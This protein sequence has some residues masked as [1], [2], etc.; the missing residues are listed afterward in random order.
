MLASWIIK[1]LLIVSFMVFGY[2]ITYILLVKK[3]NKNKNHNNNLIDQKLKETR[4]I[5]R[6]GVI[7]MNCFIFYS[8]LN[9]FFYDY[10]IR[11]L[12]RIPLFEFNYVA[13]IVGFLLVIIGNIILGF[14]Y[15]K[16]G[17]YW[18][19]PTDRISKKKVII[20]TGIYRYIRHPIYL[21][22]IIFTLGFEL[23]LLDLFS[24][25]LFLIGIIGLYFQ[26]IDEEKILSEFHGLEYT[27]YI[28]LTS[29]F[30]PIK[31]KWSEINKKKLIIPTINIILLIFF[32][33]GSLILNLPI[34]FLISAY[35]L[36]ISTITLQYDNK[37]L[38][39]LVIPLT[40]VY[41]F[42]LIQ[43]LLDLNFLFAIFHIP[44]V[45]SCQIVNLRRKSSLL[46]MIFASVSYA[47]WIFAI[48][49][50]LYFPYYQCVFYICNNLQHF[51]IILIIGLITSICSSKFVK[52]KLLQRFN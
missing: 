11:F 2:N 8:C 15:H 28:N 17:V 14:A 52:N 27:K 32:I 4:Y 25:F 34:I 26:A 6:I 31:K 7:V 19:F 12:P 38:N 36:I 3:K 1:L 20:K 47:F 13:Q 10:F 16:L 40:F 37:I 46:I 30:I 41:L 44:T 50:W 45:I 5:A 29:R 22:F 24:L 33:I 51:Y 43:D 49:E 9:I 42:A 23:I 48:K 18:S 39:S 35:A 21:S